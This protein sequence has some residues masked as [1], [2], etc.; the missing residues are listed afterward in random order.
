MLILWIR[1]F[2]TVTLILG[3]IGCGNEKQESDAKKNDGASSMSFTFFD[4]GSNTQYSDAT[5]RSLKKKLGNDA[6]SH[7]NMIKL[8]MNY[9]G[10]L[11]QYFPELDE[12]DRRLNSSI[13]ERVD[14]Y[15]TRLMYRYARKRKVPFDYVEILF[16]NYSKHP[17]LIDIQF[18]ED[19][20]GT[21][22][23]LKTKYGPSREI[24]WDK[25]S[26]KTLVWKK[27]QDYLLVSIV[28]DQFGVLEHRITIYFGDNL[29][30]LIETEQT[31]QLRSSE[32]QSKSG[33]SAF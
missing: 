12:L 26:G 13:G 1:V 16:S 29:L 32:A 2:I 20:H 30:D 4:I 5:R 7:R 31:R 14:H 27:N 28:P 11:R 18:K 15:T 33:Q 6:I 24:R 25:D 19:A 9:P 10:F 21:V 8:E 23:R 17:V 3:L 22:D